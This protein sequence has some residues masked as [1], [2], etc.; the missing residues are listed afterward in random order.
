VRTR[1]A[2]PPLLRRVVHLGV[3]FGAIGCISCDGCKGSGDKPGTDPGKGADTPAVPATPPVASPEYRTPSP[4]EFFSGNAADAPLDDVIRYASKLEWSRDTAIGGFLHDTKRKYRAVAELNTRNAPSKDFEIGRIVAK[5]WIDSGGDAELH[6]H[7]IKQGEPV[8][9]WLEGKPPQRDS[10]RP[11]GCAK[12]AR[13]RMLLFTASWGLNPGG[14]GV[15]YRWHPEQDSR[16]VRL[17]II[18]GD[19]A[20]EEDTL[21]AIHRVACPGLEATTSHRGTWVAC[22]QGCCMG[23]IP[24]PGLSTSA[25]AAK[26]VGRRR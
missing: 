10:T 7:A 23:D 20:P 8:Y 18:P 6:G 26:P 11:Q 21:P 15:L 16:S 2:L 25:A 19:S 14:R 4:R 22:L 17:A 24:D 1:L 12:F 3:L 13:G 9:V 5:F